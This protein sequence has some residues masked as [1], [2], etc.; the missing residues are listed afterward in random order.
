MK[1]IAG[2]I[3]RKVVDVT[4]HS[5]E[6]PVSD[7]KEKGERFDVN[8]KIDDGSQ[9]NLEMQAS[10]MEEDSG[11]E[12]K[13]LKSRSIYYLTD[14][15]SSQ[16]AIGERRYDRLART[17]QVTFCSYTVFPLRKEYVNSFSMRHDVDNEL[18]HDAIQTVIV[19]LSKL[20]DIVKKP[21]ET[22][23]DLEKFAVFFE[24]ADNP[25]Y[26]TT[27][28]KVIESE[29]VL[30]V[31]S[32]L[33]MNISQDEHERARIL[34]RKK[35]QMD[36]ASN[37]ATAEDRGENRGIQKGKEEEAKDILELIKSG[38]TLEQIQQTLQEKIK[39]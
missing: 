38:Y 6:L 1:L 32:N 33:L 8:T 23:T 17:Y 26:R 7:T 20:D 9:I 2:L 25:T 11:G 29:E 13:N 27:V 36:L 39:S 5:N 28:N 35:F 12:H 22:M 30:T 31:A 18:L 10:R 19:E 14:L 4:V 3:G 34:S 21:V 37:I 16:P 24:Y 15:H